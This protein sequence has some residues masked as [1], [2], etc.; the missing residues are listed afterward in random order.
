VICQGHPEKH[1]SC[2]T[3]D[4]SSA[5]GELWRMQL[6]QKNVMAPS[7]GDFLELGNTTTQMWIVWYRTNWMNL[8]ESG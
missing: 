2:E 3:A 4:A 1:T 5:C 7:Y 8:D 6:V